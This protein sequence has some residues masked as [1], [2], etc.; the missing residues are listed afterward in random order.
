MS[1]EP[2]NNIIIHLKGSETTLPLK[3]KQFSTGSKGFNAAGRFF[4]EDGKSYQA[5]INLIEIG[6]KPKTK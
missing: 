4:T 3:E 2:I 6:S 5:S 1:G